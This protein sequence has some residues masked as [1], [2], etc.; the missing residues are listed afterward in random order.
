MAQQ[1]IF[2]F[3]NDDLDLDYKATFTHIRDTQNLTL[4][5]IDEEKIIRSTGDVFQTVDNSTFYLYCGGPITGTHKVVML[6]DDTLQIQGRKLFNLDLVPSTPLDYRLALGYPGVA[7]KNILISDFIE[8]V[9]DAAASQG[10]LL[11]A[12]QYLGEIAALGLAAKESAR[13]NI[14]TYS[15][16]EITD[17]DAA[18][19]TYAQS[20]Q[21]D[22]LA[23]WQGAQTSVIFTSNPR[24]KNQM[25]YSH[26]YLGANQWS[27]TRQHIVELSFE[28]TMQGDATDTRYEL[29]TL[30]ESSKPLATT[31]FW[32]AT[33]HNA[34][35]QESCRLDYEYGSNTRK[36]YAVPGIT[37]QRWHAH[38]IY[39]S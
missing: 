27:S 39:V 23:H 9:A 19:L 34:K 32:F 11:K 22:Q 1:Q 3:T 38:I 35:T 8:D 7:D 29:M 18:V 25:L 36:V 12:D 30:G 28:F 4:N 20:V 15:R 33:C 5:W 6:F 26:I 2:T 21:A 17:K 16:Q 13:T 37:N 10:G 14:S 31:L 24:I